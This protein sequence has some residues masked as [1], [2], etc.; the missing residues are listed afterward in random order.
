MHKYNDL[1]AYITV[2]ELD[3]QPC[4]LYFVYQQVN[5]QQ[6]TVLVHLL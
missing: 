4:A 1:A 5:G 2:L 6:P 3:Q